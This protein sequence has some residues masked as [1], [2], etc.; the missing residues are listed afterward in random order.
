VRRARAGAVALGV[1]AVLILGWGPSASA[2][3]PESLASFAAQSSAVPYGVLS[4]V[5]V[6]SA[7]GFL[8][9]QS[10]VRLGKATA[11]A[12][13]FTAGEL[14]D[15]FIVSSSPP[16]TIT[17]MPTVI[18]AQEPPSD[19][20]PREARLTGG[21]SGSPTTGQVQNFDLLAKADDAPA[22]NASAVGQGITALPFSSGLSTSRSESIVSDDGT[23]AT[24]AITSVQNLVIGPVAT[25]LS[26]AAVE[27]IASITIPPGGKPVADLRT[28]MTGAML[29]GVPVTLDSRGIR[30]SDQVALPPDALAAFKSGLDSLAEHGL[31]FEPA[32]REETVTADGAKLSGAVF[33]F[34]YRYPD[35]FPRPSDIGTDETFQFAAVTAEATARQ[36]TAPP[37]TTGI[38]DAPTDAAVPA[39]TSAVTPIEELPASTDPGIAI[40][41]VAGAPALDLPDAAPSAGAPPVAGAADPEVVFALPTRVADPLPGQ[42]RDSYRYVMLAA[43]AGIGAVL[44]LRKTIV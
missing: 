32:P 29:G 31:F 8:Y 15:V 40:P 22:G 14:G 23:V 26:I 25:G 7:G 41:D 3:P 36:R 12:A 11:R 6:E 13:G 17:S 28:T 16:G 43:V 19:V 30:I 4:R 44:V 10:G 35:A 38:S 24:K 1:G 9:S 33:Q 18:N 34:R 27:S 20:A 21:T 37:P 5:P 42:A 39:D 2:A